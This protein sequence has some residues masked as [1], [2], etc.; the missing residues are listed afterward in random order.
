MKE[1]FVAEIKKHV[2]SN[3]C[4]IMAQAT[5]E[6]C[7]LL[8]ANGKDFIFNERTTGG[9]DHDRV[10]GIVQVN[11][12]NGYFTMNDASP[13]PI[14][15]KPFLIDTLSRILKNGTSALAHHNQDDNK[16]KADTILTI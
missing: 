14:A 10:L 4:Y 6:N 13:Y 15:P 12:A 9:V 11:I 1:V 16:V 8:T 7:D 3:D 2:P 5:I